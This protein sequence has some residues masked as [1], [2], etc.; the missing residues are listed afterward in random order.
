MFTCFTAAR[1]YHCMHRVSF[2]LRMTSFQIIV[3]YTVH[4]CA[5]W[6][7][8]GQLLINVDNTKAVRRCSSRAIKT[9]S[10]LSHHAFF[11]TSGPAK[12]AS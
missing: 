11:L 2:I 7:A 1:S 10:T 4:K 12:A 3:A 5:T 8:L 6:S 9:L